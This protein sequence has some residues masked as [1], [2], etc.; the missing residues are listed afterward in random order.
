MS[1]TQAMFSTHAFSHR[2]QRDENQDRLAVL[3]S[4]D[5]RSRLL[6]VADG[7]GGH[8]GAS[9]AAQTVVATAERCWQCRLPEQ[10]SE[11]FLKHLVRESHTA[12]RRAGREQELDPHSTLAALL[13]QET[14]AASIH[15]GDSRVIQFSGQAFIDRTLDHSIA[16]LHVL[17]GL[18]ADEDMATH[19]DQTILFSQVGG[20]GSP[21]A[22][23]NHWDL[24]KGRRFVV[25]SDGFWEVFPP[26]EMLELFASNDPESEMRQRFQRK[27]KHLERHDNTTAILVEVA[28][29]P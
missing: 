3:G 2:G 20:P 4:T 21:D 24:S 6:V 7:L 25:C 5:D 29:P 17:R 8:S 26:E 27:L 22:E 13:L 12:V 16:Q 14:E 18:I 28:P 1:F 11:A 9:L 15:A 10:G 19:P 23:V